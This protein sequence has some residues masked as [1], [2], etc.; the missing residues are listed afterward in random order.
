MPARPPVVW[1]FA[2]QHSLKSVHI[3]SLH[4]EPNNAP[5]CR[6][7]RPAPGGGEAY[8]KCDVG[9]GVTIRVD[10]ELIRRRG[11]ERLARGG[12]WRVHDG[13]RMDVHDQDRLARLARLREGIEIG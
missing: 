5:Q 10:L 4:E 1:A 11:R 9:N 13:G 7:L 8:P 3:A 12:P 2:V 6:G